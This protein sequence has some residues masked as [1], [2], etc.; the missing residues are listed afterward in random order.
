MVSLAIW[1]VAAFICIVAFLNVLA[2]GGA[3]IKA[4]FSSMVKSVSAPILQVSASPTPPQPRV[5]GSF[6]LRLHT[7]R[8]K[9][10]IAFPRNPYPLNSSPTASAVQD[11]LARSTLPRLSD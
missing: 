3:I 10:P 7:L 5:R 8:A 6:I 9:Q 2:I 1:I 11:L 4:I